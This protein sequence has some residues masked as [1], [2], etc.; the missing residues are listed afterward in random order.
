MTSTKNG[1]PYA[2]V[3][4]SFPL[5]AEPTLLDQ[6]DQLFRRLP[7]RLPVRVVLSP[8]GLLRLQ[9]ELLAFDPVQVSSSDGSVEHDASLVGSYNG[10]P[11][12]LSEG[13][14]VECFVEYEKR[15]GEN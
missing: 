15:G 8:A 1:V 7:G 9:R 6:V 10:I 2:A 14:S 12:F 11:I 4:P 3:E 13:S 5:P